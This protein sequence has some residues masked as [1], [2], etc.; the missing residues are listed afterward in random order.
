MKP[1]LSIIT[2]NRNNAEGLRKT[3]ESVV[4]Q[5]DLKDGELE[6]IIID[7][8]STDSSI[9][10]I[11]EFVSHP[12]YGKRITYWV[13]EPDTGI[14]NAMNKG[15]KKATGEYIHI[16]NSGDFYTA[17]ACSQILF[18]L[19]NS[20]DCIFFGVNLIRNDEIKKMELRYPS[21]LKDS[22]ILHQG[23]IYRKSFHETLGLY[24]ESYKYAAD[25]DFTIK[26]FQDENVKITYCYQ[27]L[28]NFP[29]FGSGYSSE[30]SDEAKSVRIKYGYL[31]IKKEK[32]LKRILRKL[33]KFFK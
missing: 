19:T 33:V 6:Y 21:I 29:E 14:Y 23:L 16:L 7:G 15:I 4:S 8:A 3:I 28:V 27:P 20:I 22:T 13:S 32:R 24:D 5:T 12:I 25:Y 10:V 2:I 1:R 11:N 17:N 18:L 9:D 30:A 26:L 31:Q